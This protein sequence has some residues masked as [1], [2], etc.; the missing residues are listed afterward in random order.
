M[1]VDME[2]FGAPNVFRIPATNVARR[3]HLGGCDRYLLRSCLREVRA[4]ES[5]KQEKNRVLLSAFDKATMEKGHRFEADVLQRLPNVLW[6]NEEAEESNQLMFQRLLNHVMN[7]CG[8][9]CYAW[10]IAFDPSLAQFAEFLCGSAD[11]SFAVG[12]I[13][14]DFWDCFTMKTG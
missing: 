3:F 11:P 10:G 8:Q 9:S 14:I 13:I 1:D 7:H 12:P 5:A 6:L 2:D 4:P